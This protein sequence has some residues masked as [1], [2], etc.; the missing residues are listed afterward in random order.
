MLTSFATYG[1]SLKTAVKVLS[2]SAS[3]VPF[4]RL[5][6]M[7]KEQADAVQMQAFINLRVIGT[8]ETHVYVRPCFFSL[9]STRVLII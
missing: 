8:Q 4:D 9:P 2:E 5:E 7:N 3:G 1:Q 6:E